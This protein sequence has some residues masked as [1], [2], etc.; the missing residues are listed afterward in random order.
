MK[1]IKK[2]KFR[3]FKSRLC[4]RFHPIKSS[5]YIRRWLETK[6]HFHQQISPN[7]N[8]V[9]RWWPRTVLV[10]LANGTVC[11]LVQL[12]QLNCNWHSENRSIPCLEVGKEKSLSDSLCLSLNLSLRSDQICSEIVRLNLLKIRNV[13]YIKGRLDVF[14]CQVITI[15][16]KLGGR[17][18]TKNYLWWNILKE[19]TKDWPRPRSSTSLLNLLHSAEVRLWRNTE[20]CG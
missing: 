11:L 9:R 14:T 7:K 3:L 17:D 1:T 8:L 12:Q 15:R 2:G 6:Q 13:E 19:Q 20:I 10:V 5:P 18:M 4:D 16:N